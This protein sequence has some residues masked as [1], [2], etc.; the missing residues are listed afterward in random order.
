MK[1]NGREVQPSDHKQSSWGPKIELIP[2]LISQDHSAPHFKLKIDFNI[3]TY[4]CRTKMGAIYQMINIKVKHFR[5]QLY[6]Y[7]YLVSQFS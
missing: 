2:S 6:L 7:I 4:T 3:R 5:T 1:L